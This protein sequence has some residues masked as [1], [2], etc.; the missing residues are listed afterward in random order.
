[1]IRF[2]SSLPSW[3]DRANK[4][5]T[6]QVAA[7]IQPLRRGRLG[8]LRRAAREPLPAADPARGRPADGPLPQGA[9]RPGPGRRHK[10]RA[11]LQIFK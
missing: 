8:H 10:R 3:V 4:Y 7:A 2:N 6:A 9:A 5:R 1:M 11:W